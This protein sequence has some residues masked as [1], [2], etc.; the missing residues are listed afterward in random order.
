MDFV[1]SQISRKSETNGLLLALAA[2]FLW[3][4][5]F[6]CSRFLVSSVPQKMDSFSL[7]M[8]RFIIGPAVIF[9]LGWFLKKP[10]LL[11]NPRQVYQTAAMSFFF[12]WL[13]TVLLFYGV[14][15]SSAMV[16]A[17]Y[18]ESGPALLVILWKLIRRKPTSKS[19]IVAIILGVLGSTLVLN[20]FT[21]TAN[22]DLLGQIC[23]LISAISWVIGSLVGEEL[24][25]SDNIFAITAWSQVFSGFYTIPLLWLMHDKLVIPTQI[26][27]YIA[28]L[29]IG[30]FPTALAFLAW[31]YAM[32]R[33]PLWKLSLMKNM[34]PIFTLIGAWLIIG[35]KITMS[36]VLGGV[37]VVVGLSI[38]VIC[39]YKKAAA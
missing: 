29:V 36:N 18:V 32:A 37:I 17:L 23:L 11:K 33:L 20:I 1:M 8:S 4:L 35:E 22:A 25:Q 31:S 16:G 12:Y 30:I 9:G 15:S 5:A 26:S 14:K 13:M 38:A 2:T 10:L 3:S 21:G 34:T 28:V 19:E 27:A 39:N 24:M 7:T 6:V